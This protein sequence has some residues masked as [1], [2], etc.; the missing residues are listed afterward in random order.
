MAKEKIKY[1]RIKD[2]K[3]KLKILS[4]DDKI[5]IVKNSKEQVF[6]IPNIYLEKPS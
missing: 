1:I 6:K 5:T 4:R 2:T 3:E